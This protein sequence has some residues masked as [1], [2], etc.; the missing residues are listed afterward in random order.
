MF[1]RLPDLL[2]GTRVWVVVSENRIAEGTSH[3][4]TPS[5]PE[6][7][8]C[9]PPGDAV[10]KAFSRRASYV[11]CCLGTHGV[12]SVWALLKPRIPAAE[13]LQYGSVTWRGLHRIA[14]AVAAVAL[15][16][17]IIE[18]NPPLM[19][20]VRS[21]MGSFENSAAPRVG[22]HNVHRTQQQAHARCRNKNV[23]A[24]QLMHGRQPH[25]GVLRDTGRDLKL[26][27][28]LPRRE[29]WCAS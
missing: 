29:Q 23:S 15:G 27:K 19:S 18:C 28:P 24:S 8:W 7:L 1:C 26:S 13:T 22:M 4:P 9:T 11:L 17:A 21:S 5:R 10:C 3:R 6:A 12:D 25:K 16:R 20:T 14:I 2:I